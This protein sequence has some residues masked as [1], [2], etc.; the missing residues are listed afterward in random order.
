MKSIVLIFQVIFNRFHSTFVYFS[1]RNLSHSFTSS[2][3]LLQ[4]SFV[5]DFLL[6]P[7]LLPSILSLSS[8]FEACCNRRHFNHLFLKSLYS[9]EIFFPEVS[10]INLCFRGRCHK[11]DLS[12][13]SLLQPLIPP[14]SPSCYGNNQCTLV[15]SSSPHQSRSLLEELTFHYTLDYPDFTRNLSG[16][17]P[18]GFRSSSSYYENIPF[19]KQ[20]ETLVY[21]NPTVRFEVFV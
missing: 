9:I 20:P 7:R 3:T 17:S 16:H 5:I 1:R 15:S 4:K 18:K 6:F 19:P 2:N 10:S 11:P 21:F 14:S 8:F 12:F 13:W